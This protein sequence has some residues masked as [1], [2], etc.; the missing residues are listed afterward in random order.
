VKGKASRKTFL[1]IPPTRWVCHI[2]GKD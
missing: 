2:A 1:T